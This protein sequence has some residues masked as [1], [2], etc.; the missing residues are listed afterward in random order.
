MA[1]EFCKH[2]RKCNCAELIKNIVEKKTEKILKC[3]FCENY[4]DTEIKLYNHLCDK[5]RKFQQREDKKVRLGFLLFQQ[6]CK[7]KGNK[8][9][10]TIEKFESSNLYSSFVGFST[11]LHKIHAIN[12][13]GFL[14]FLLSANIGINNWKQ[15]KYYQR[16]VREMNKIED[17]YKAVERNIL[18]MQQ[19]SLQT[20]EHWTEFFR[21][22]APPQAVLWIQSGRLSPWMLFSCPESSAEMLKRM[23]EEQINIINDVIDSKYWEIKLSRHTKEVE[24][25][26]KI[27]DEAGL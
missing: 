12:P 14:D 1:S 16:Y 8:T 2:K 3:D 18:L 7:R 10:P 11:Y 19:W 27:M 13:I 22:V 25:I 21:K 15:D 4:F 17:P 6:F 5:K 9:I 23:S 26:R 20:E 24:Y